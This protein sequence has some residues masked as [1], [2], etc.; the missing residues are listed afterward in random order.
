MSQK[1]NKMYNVVFILIFLMLMLC[2]METLKSKNPDTDYTIDYV[3]I[4][5]FVT[6]SIIIIMSMSHMALPQ[7]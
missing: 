3:T 1:V 5:T 4:F 6:F 7:N 2:N